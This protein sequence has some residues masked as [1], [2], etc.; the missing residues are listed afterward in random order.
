MQVLKPKPSS[1]PNSKAGDRPILQLL[2]HPLRQPSH[3]QPPLRAAPTPLHQPRNRP[4]R[5]RWGFV[6]AGARRL[7]RLPG[8]P[9]TPPHRVA[10]Q[11]RKAPHAAPRSPRAGGL[12]VFGRACSSGGFPR[13]EEEEGT[14]HG[15]VLWGWLCVWQKGIGWE[16]VGAAGEEQG[17]RCRGSR[18][19]LCYLQLSSTFSVTF[20]YT[21]Y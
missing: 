13:A 9:A 19:H 20:Q 21:K 15:L 7:V 18:S 8:C 12:S 1:N 16:S 17:G 11:M 2:Q 4:E 6:P 3:R 5:H 10:C 14:C